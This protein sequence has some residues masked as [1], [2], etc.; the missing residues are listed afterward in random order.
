MERDRDTERNIEKEKKECLNMCVANKYARYS[1]RVD[2]PNTHKLN[3]QSK[4]TKTQ[5]GHTTQ[6][7]NAYLGGG[8]AAEVLSIHMSHHNIPQTIQTMNTLKLLSK[9]SKTHD[10]KTQKR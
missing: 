1:I 3:A 6:R 5:R 8:L 2:T 10:T 4:T 9:I 7:Q